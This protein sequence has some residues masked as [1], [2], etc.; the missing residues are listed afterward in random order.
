MKS[1]SRM[2]RKH[3]LPRRQAVDAFARFLRNRWHVGRRGRIRACVGWLEAD[4]CPGLIGQMNAARER[5]RE[6]VH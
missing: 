6:I 2:Q 4:E 1:I 3:G 5:A